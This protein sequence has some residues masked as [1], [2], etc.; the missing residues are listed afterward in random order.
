MLFRKISIII[1]VYNEKSTI[2]E[3]LE[4]V[5]AIELPLEKEI[6]IV[7]DGSQDGTRDILKKLPGRRRVIFHERNRGKGAAVRAGFA[8]ASG[9]I[10]LI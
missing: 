5:E 7:D 3:I 8:A 1:P 4:R 2:E 6:I 10:I 9:D